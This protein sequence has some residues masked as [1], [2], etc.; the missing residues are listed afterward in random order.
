MVLHRRLKRLALRPDP[1]H[2]HLALLATTDN[3]PAVRRA[4][5][6]R[7]GLEMRIIDGVQQLAALWAKRTDL[8]IAPSADDGLAVSGEDDAACLQVWDADAQQ[9]AA[10]A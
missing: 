1:P 4:C 6:R 7:D 9:L 5:K 2:A 8:A 3:P 10:A